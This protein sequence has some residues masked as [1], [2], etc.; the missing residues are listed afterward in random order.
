MVDDPRQPSSPTQPSS[1]AQPSSSPQPSGSEADGLRIAVLGPGGVGG[2]LAALLARAGNDVL[3]LAGQQTAAAIRERGLKV[4]SERFGTFAVPVR[5]AE[6]LAEPVDVCLVTVKAPLLD[7]A[8]E[9]VP[10]AALGDALVVPLLNGVEH[11]D[12]L[13]SCYPQATVVAATIRVE[14]AREAPGEIRQRSPFAAL[15]LAAM[16]PAEAQ[17]RH[18]AAH[19]GRAGLDVRVRP[20]DETGVLWDKLGFLGPLALL[21]THAQ[22]PAGVV[23]EARRDDLEAV[24]TEVA[25]VARA[26]GATGDGA[27]VLSFFDGVPAPMRSSMQRD[28]EAGL[29][30]ELDAICGAVLRA[31][32]RHGIDVPV[33]ARLV[34]ELQRR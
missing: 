19:L 25:A 9:R 13:R 18:F 28:A 29:P 4:V 7:E 32:E 30:T 6:E 27:A 31:A 16:P 20:G 12:T 15:E 3:C 21:T 11:V 33:T 22:A 17:V 1:P 34:R 10:A 5:A 23:R 14:S 2:L 26:E 8:L 24:I